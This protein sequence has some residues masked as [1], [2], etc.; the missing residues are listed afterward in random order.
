MFRNVKNNVSKIR[1]SNLQNKKVFLSPNWKQNLRK[2]LNVS[3]HLVTLN[4]KN[5]IGT[6]S[7]L[8]Y[9]L[10]KNIFTNFLGIPQK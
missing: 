10:S 8:K 6:L 2:L 3:E 5:Y 9:L 1:W 7:K 4:Y